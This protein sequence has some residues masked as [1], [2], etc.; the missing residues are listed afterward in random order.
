LSWW[1]NLNKEID[2]AAKEHWANTHLY[3][4]PTP[5]SLSAFK[6]WHVLLYHQQKLSRVQVKLI[7][8]AIH[9]P[10]MEEYWEKR[11][12]NYPTISKMTNILGW[13]WSRLKKTEAKQTPSDG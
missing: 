7:Y 1:E 13:H 9:T 3:D 10:A 11:K 8:E 2:L 6:G 5:A 12:K 4:R